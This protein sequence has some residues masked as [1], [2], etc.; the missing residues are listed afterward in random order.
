MADPQQLLAQRFSRAIA[1]AFGEQYADLDPLIR[2]SG[3]PQFGDYQAN[4]AMNLGKTLQ[5]K[6]RDV[7]QRIVEHLD[8]EGICHPTMPQIAGPGFINLRL[9]PVFMNHQIAALAGDTRLGVTPTTHPATVVVDYG[10]PNVAKEMHVGHLRSAIIGD[11]IVRVLQHLGHHVIRQNH[12][13]DWGTQFG[14]LIQFML[15]SDTSE[16]LDNRAIG[17]LNVLYQQA[18]K[19][20]DADAEFAARARQR[21]VALQSGDEATRTIWRQ[22]VAASQRHFQEVY[23]RLGVLLTDDDVRGESFYNDRLPVVARDL[24]KTGLLQPSQGAAVVFL[25]GFTDDAGEPLPLIVRKSD[26]AYLYATTDLAAARFRIEELGAT[27]VIYVTDVRQ[28]QHFAMVFAALRKAHWAPPG[29]RL[30]HVAFGTMLGADRKPFKTRSGEM[31]R[32]ADLL[33]EAGRRAAA[34]LEAKNPDMTDA[35]RRR[36]AQIVGIGA[37]KYADLSSDRIKDYVFDWD[38]MLA[39]EGNTAP[40]LLNAYVRIRSIFRKGNVDLETLSPQS[41]RVDEPVEWALALK[42][43]QLPSVVAAV[44]ES[45]EPHRLCTYLYELASLYHQF[46]EQCPVLGADDRLRQSRLILSR[47]TALTLKQGLEL[48][49]IEVIEQM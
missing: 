11:A 16:R 32:L 6:P 22:L 15:E 5:L 45:L 35:E 13:G 41:V 25:E 4:V 42:L 48:L 30:D 24:E 1:R 23:G 28:A 36:V 12:I 44:A 2:T 31:I 34:V 9:A 37:L 27:R 43:L 19:R 29:V 7:A 3:N 46:Y 33:D 38:R 39:M 49:G 17:D 14:M 26:G 47:V 10:G 40:Y 8:L 18:K 21:V 20:F